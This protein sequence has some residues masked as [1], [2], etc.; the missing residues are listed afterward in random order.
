MHFTNN[1]GEVYTIAIQDAYDHYKQGIS[2]SISNLA[3]EILTYGVTTDRSTYLHKSIKTYQM[4]NSSNLNE[5][6]KN[7]E[8]IDNNVN[9]N[10]IKNIFQLNKY[11][12]FINKSN[13]VN[14]KL[15]IKISKNSN[16]NIQYA[17][18]RSNGV[19]FQNDSYYVNNNTE[20][21]ELNL[22]AGKIVT[23]SL[24]EKVETY[25]INNILYSI[26]LGFNSN[27]TQKIYIV[28]HPT[29]NTLEKSEFFDYDN[30]LHSSELIQNK[31]IAYNKYY[32]IFNLKNELDINIKLDNSNYKYHFYHLTL[33][34]NNINS[35][36]DNNEFNLKIKENEIFI[37]KVTQFH[38]ELTHEEVNKLSISGFRKM[39]KLE[40]KNDGVQLLPFISE[41]ILDFD[42]FKLID[43]ENSIIDKWGLN[44]NEYNFETNKAMGKVIALLFKDYYK[45]LINVRF[46]FYEKEINNETTISYFE[47]D[48]SGDLILHENIKDLKSKYVILYQYINQVSDSINK[49]T[50]KLSNSHKSQ[51]INF[52]SSLNYN[53]LKNN[54]KIYIKKIRLETSNND[55]I[56]SNTLNSWQLARFYVWVNNE[57]MMI[58][59]KNKINSTGYKNKYAT[60]LID[61]QK[62]NSNLLERNSINNISSIKNNNEVEYIWNNTTYKITFPDMYAGL[63]DIVLYMN[64]IFKKNN[65]YLVDK[66]DNIIYPI[67]LEFNSDKT[68]IYIFINY[69]PTSATDSLYPA[70]KNKHF[71]FPTTGFYS[72]LK[73]I[74][75]TNF[76]KYIGVS[77]NYETITKDCKYIQEDNKIRDISTSNVEIENTN[78]YNPIS[79]NISNIT[80]HVYQSGIG[81]KLDDGKQY[82]EVILKNKVLYNDFQNIT[83]LSNKENNI[84]NT[85][86]LFYDEFGNKVENYSIDFNEYENKEENHEIFLLKGPNFDSYSDNKK[87]PD[88]DNKPTDFALNHLSSSK[89]I[90]TKNAFNINM[91]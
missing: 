61:H 4:E 63:E 27:Y 59:N 74:P 72:I 47:Y 18:Y 62:H 26:N 58:E 8:I 9:F 37:F 49:K 88:Y 38:T 89:I 21:I 56:S 50:L 51:E 39:E 67:E 11:Y 65:H 82:W 6:D 76:Y 32:T 23:I 10:D 1:K 20:F 48:T 66:L 13:N 7:H 19:F 40:V 75:F 70:N 60:N 69:I 35:I 22:G 30:N 64:Y 55:F 84:Y 83:I 41:D 34:N 81:E 54:K 14:D 85:S 87:Y 5:V 79:E 31:Y 52:Y 43:N 16:Y 53:S 15:N 73:M 36:N 17:F 33:E 25:V 45:H 90:K 3:N 77:K 78:F 44:N 29:Y 28:N 42:K 71:T 91:N 12:T 80:E 57:N 86:L 46:P 2:G 24:Q 68:K